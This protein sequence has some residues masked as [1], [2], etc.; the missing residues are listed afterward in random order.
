MEYYTRIKM[1]HSYLQQ[2]IQTSQ[3]RTS[4]T[5][6]QKK[7]KQTYVFLGMQACT[8]AIYRKAGD[9]QKNLGL[10]G[11]WAYQGKQET[12]I[13]KGYSKR[14]GVLEVIQFLDLGLGRLLFKC[15]I[16]LYICFMNFLGMLT[17]FK[18]KNILKN[19]TR[20]VLS[21]LEKASKLA[22]L[23]LESTGPI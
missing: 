1:N 19:L 11:S 15:I 14:S 2:N 18:M 6:V 22:I 3:S 23:Y 9:Y 8:V 20:H 10:S 5:E 7:A 13:R 12:L 16:K 17:Y 4:F 21:I